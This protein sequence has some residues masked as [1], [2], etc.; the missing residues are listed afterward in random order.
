MTTLAKF[1]SYR[2]EW[3]T[4]SSDLEK[5]ITFLKPNCKEKC[6]C[7]IWD[8]LG[9]Y[10][11]GKTGWQQVLVAQNQK[12]RRHKTRPGFH[13]VVGFSLAWSCSID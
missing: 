6:F 1:M 9:S 13:S 11:L 2:N 7:S 8:H 12:A 4:S 5:E 10:K 3:M